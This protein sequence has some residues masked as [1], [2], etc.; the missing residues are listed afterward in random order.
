MEVLEKRELESMELFNTYISKLCCPTDFAEAS[1]LISYTNDH[2]LCASYF[3]NDTSEVYYSRI[4]KVSD[5]GIYGYASKSDKYSV[6]IRPAIDARSIKRE[7][8]I[9]GQIVNNDLSVMEYGYYPK[10]L[11]RKQHT[12]EDTGL[13]I[14]LPIANIYFIEYP[15]HSMCIKIRNTLFTHGDTA[16]FM[17]EP[18]R[19]WIDNKTNLCITQDVILGGVSYKMYDKKDYEYD[20]YYD[21]DLCEAIGIMD[22]TMESLTKLI[23]E[24]NKGKKKRKK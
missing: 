10:S 15:I 12:K 5:T 1:G 23:N 20:D 11:I 18:V 17:I 24:Y 3:V 9:D 14:K 8:I 7:L 19:F 22:E 16:T 13:R 4:S 21:S 2:L 6:G